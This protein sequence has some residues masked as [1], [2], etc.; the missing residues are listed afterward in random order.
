MFRAVFPKI[1]SAGLTCACV[2]PVS[3]E[4]SLPYYETHTMVLAMTCQT[5]ET[6]RSSTAQP[7]PAR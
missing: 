3:V 2:F 5:P 1:R 4:N 7:A 6:L